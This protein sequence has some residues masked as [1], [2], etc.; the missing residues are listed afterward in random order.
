MAI[1][2]SSLSPFSD[3]SNTLPRNAWIRVSLATNVVSR[4]A[5]GVLHRSSQRR[6]RPFTKPS[7]DI[8]LARALE[9]SQESYAAEQNVPQEKSRGFVSAIAGDRREEEELEWVLRTSGAEY[10][11]QQEDE[12]QRQKGEEGT[13]TA[14]TGSAKIRAMLVGPFAPETSFESN[15]Q[16]AFHFRKVFAPKKSAGVIEPSTA[17]GGVLRSHVQGWLRHLRSAAEKVQLKTPDIGPSMEEDYNR[18]DVAQYVTEGSF[19]PDLTDFYRKYAGVVEPVHRTSD[20]CGNTRVLERLRD[21]FLLVHCL[22]AVR[23]MQLRMIL[24]H[25]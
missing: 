12:R 21:V 6:D 10:K 15:E 1:R 17:E 18:I 16:S 25:L 4:T 3:D 14:T 8:V 13:S 22:K 7:E 2:K 9:A 5:G 20:T 19:D 11:G 24:N 23:T